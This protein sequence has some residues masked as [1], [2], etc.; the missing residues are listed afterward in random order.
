MH[1][2]I[3][4]SVLIAV[5]RFALIA[6]LATV[7]ASLFYYPPPVVLTA[8]LTG[9]VLAI[10]LL[11]LVMPVLLPLSY[12]LVMA[13]SGVG[14]AILVSPVLLLLLL[15][16]GGTIP[17]FTILTIMGLAGLP[18]MLGELL[19]TVWKGNA[20]HLGLDAVAASPRPGQACPPVV[21]MPHAHVATSVDGGSSSGSSPC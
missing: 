9:V 1:M 15:I 16:P 11:L 18:I 4:R 19:R 6:G 17:V 7:A 13:L 12:I 2:A 3:V 8:T 21:F 10:P 5:L 20:D 14:L